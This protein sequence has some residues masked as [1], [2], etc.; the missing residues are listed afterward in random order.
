MAEIS[1]EIII[2]VSSMSGNTVISLHEIS[3]QGMNMMEI[4]VSGLPAGI[5]LL[6]LQ[7]G[8]ER[9]YGKVVVE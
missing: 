8:N 6:E 1:D 3:K 4:D 5:Y 9:A 7:S 2:S